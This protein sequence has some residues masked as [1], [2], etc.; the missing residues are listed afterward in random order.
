MD[1]DPDFLR[2]HY[3]SLSDDALLEVNRAELVDVAQGC[4]DDEMKQ[5]GLAANGTSPDGQP[6]DWLDGA[7]EIYSAPDQR[8]GV[9]DTI[10]DGQKALQAAGIPSHVEF[11]EPDEEGQTGEWKLL[12]PGEVN[13]H[14]TSILERDIFN[15]EFED[16]WKTHLEMLSD[17]QLLAMT[18]QFVFCG[19][20]DKVERVNRV[21]AEEIARRES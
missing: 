6:P 18:P 5:R 17:D 11:K 4:Y 8:F 13:L 20:F 12:V 19:L 15:Q 21:Y 9:P 1:L 10:V 14:A 7:A 16:T 2:A 3:K